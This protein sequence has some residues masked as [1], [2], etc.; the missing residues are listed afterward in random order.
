M[1]GKRRCAEAR[2]PASAR[3]EEVLAAPSPG[4]SAARA[5]SV[6]VLAAP[7]TGRRPSAHHRKSAG[8]AQ[9]P[10]QGE[11]LS[12]PIPRPKRDLVEPQPDSKRT[13]H[14]SGMSEPIRAKHQSARVEM[15]CWWPELTTDQPEL[16]EM[17]C[18]KAELTPPTSRGRER[19]RRLSRKSGCAAAEE[20]EE[21][22]TGEQYIA[23][24]SRRRC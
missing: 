1:A 15:V 20:R 13:T 17:A 24:A 9:R 23:Q 22:Q 2:D 4:R 8:G 10:C 7:S 21:E 3:N 19:E 5:A 18:W 11:V 12:G 16:R 14:Q 6:A